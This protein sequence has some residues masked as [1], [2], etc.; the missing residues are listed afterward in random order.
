[1]KLKLNT[2]VLKNQRTTPEPE[3]QTPSLS[4]GTPTEQ[5]FS[6]SF[7]NNKEYNLDDIIFKKRRDNS[8]CPLI[9]KV[10]LE[11]KNDEEVIK[12]ITKLILD[13]YG[14]QGVTDENYKT[15][16][17]QVPEFYTVF[18]TYFNKYYT[19][20]YNELYNKVLN[21]SISIDTAL[22]EI[23]TKHDFA[24]EL[25]EDSSRTKA[26]ANIFNKPHVEYEYGT[27]PDNYVG[28]L[29]KLRVASDIEGI[30]AEEDTND[31]HDKLVLRN[32]EG[33]ILEQ[34]TPVYLKR[35]NGETIF[36]QGNIQ[37]STLDDYLDLMTR[38]MLITA[39]DQ[40]VTTADDEI[41][42]IISVNEE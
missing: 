37:L 38:C 14:I 39:D 5:G 18:D 42:D 8:K 23:V 22:E 9:V 34:Q 27:S 3:P 13:D 26:Y 10:N 35:I 36:G 1:M 11:N 40:Y 20:Y 21:G 24:S 15:L 2:D 32:S 33:Q 41:V 16:V 30:K 29:D 31:P 28:T 6:L 19:Y 4:T 12:L 25:L 17:N 7:T